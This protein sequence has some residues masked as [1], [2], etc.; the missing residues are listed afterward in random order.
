MALA[1]VAAPKFRP[2]QQR[3]IAKS[4]LLRRWRAFE[5]SSAASLGSRSTHAFSVPEAKM[6]TLSC[7][8]AFAKISSE[9]N[10]AIRMGY[11]SQK[12]PELL[13]KTLAE[14]VQ[15]GNR[16]FGGHLVNHFL[17][18]LQ[19]GVL[20]S[21]LRLD[22]NLILA[23]IRKCSEYNHHALI[24]D[25]WHSLAPE[26]QSDRQVVQAVLEN[27]DWMDVHYNQQDVLRSMM[28]QWSSDRDIAMA[29][30]KLYGPA[31]QQVS[32]DLREDRDIVLVALQC[33]AHLA[34]TLD[35][36]PEASQEFFERNASALQ[37]A[38]ALRANREFLL[39][40]FERNPH[41][42]HFMAQE[43]W[44]DSEFMLEILKHQPATASLIMEAL[45]MIP[46]LT[47][48]FDEEWAHYHHDPKLMVDDVIPEKFITAVIRKMVSKSAVA[49]ELSQHD[50]HRELR[51]AVAGRALQKLK[52]AI[53]EAV[54]WNLDLCEGHD[55][56]V[57][58]E[59]LAGC[60]PC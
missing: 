22:R 23:A 43:C 47:L 51:S 18:G 55:F 17:E 30:V 56:F 40:V 54:T 9:D 12:A 25:I 6:S 24:F 26:W 28:Q 45:F 44:A 60:S 57:N 38:P 46:D 48:L 42:V 19:A 53:A 2:L 33:K 35:R 49:H 58:E 36:I 21:G 29:A 3:L 52:D 27:A 4:A 7:L 14:M 37:F 1:V 31:L 15:V 11:V 32:A 10:H 50:R 16:G 34:S 39:S 41:A 5:R 8:P 13:E 20:F 59:W